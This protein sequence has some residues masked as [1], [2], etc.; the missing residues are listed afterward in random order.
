MYRP[1]GGN[2]TPSGV[3]LLY[4]LDGGVNVSPA[5]QFA[6]TTSDDPGDSMAYTVQVDVD[7]DFG[8]LG[9]QNSVEG[10]EGTSTQVPGL[11]GG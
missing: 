5:V 3:Q 4:P 10:V 2:T 7:G 9:D 6:W 11:V 1:S 8:T